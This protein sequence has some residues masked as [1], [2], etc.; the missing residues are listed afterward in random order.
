MSDELLRDRIARLVRER[1][2]ADRK[3][4]EAL[5]ALDRALGAKGTFPDPPAPADEAILDALSRHADVVPAAPPGSDRSVKGRLRTFIWRMIGPPLEAQ[6]TFNTSVVSQAS[7]ATAERA[8]LLATVE[9]TV[10][11]LREQTEARMRFESHLIQYLQ[12]V[13]WYVDTKDRLIGADAQVINAGLSAMSDDWLK[14][15]ESLQTRETRWLRQV[16]Q[17]TRSIDDVRATASIAQQTS[18]SLKREVEALLARSGGQSASPTPGPSPLPL[19]ASVPDLDAFKYLAFEN[20]FRGSPDDIR[21]RLSAYVPLFEG[22]QDVLEI[23]CGRGEFLALLQER[24]IS[25]RG[26]DLNEAMVQETRDRG[27]Q[28][29][30]ADALEYLTAL[31]D[32]SLGGV[33]AAQVVE[34]LEPGYLGRLVETATH[35]LRPGGLVVFETINPTCWV[36]FFESYIRDLTHV[37]PLHPETLQFLLRA[38]G[39]SKV[40]I[41]LTSP[42]PEAQRLARMPW[43]FTFDDPAVRDAFTAIVDGVNAHADALNA[44]LFSFQDYAV[45]GEK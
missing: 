25:A 1:D 35:K 19:N 11:V 4:N 30:R 16:E 40:D 44:R 22:R 10:A 7:R 5:T 37:R 42:V 41:K 32:A 39:L 3:Y 20:A 9:R 27:L 34:H 38:A 17:L 43:Q 29:V 14:R 6:R 28:A 24:G 33:F 13:T 36:A 21:Q 45:I 18:L 31:P 26:L 23:G 2:E 15:W 12:T 8:A